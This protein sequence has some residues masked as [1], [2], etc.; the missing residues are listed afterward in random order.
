MGVLP[1]ERI[2]VPV[3]DPG[4]VVVEHLAT[5]QTKKVFLSLKRIRRRGLILKRGE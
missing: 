1:Y 4:S 2:A 3:N 5:N